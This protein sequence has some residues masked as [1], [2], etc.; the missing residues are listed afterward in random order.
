MA[1]FRC[2]VC[3]HGFESFCLAAT[4]LRVFT[5]E[6]GPGVPASSSPCH[7]AFPSALGR[8]RGLLFQFALGS[9]VSQGYLD[10]YSK[11]CSKEQPEIRRQRLVQPGAEPLGRLPDVQTA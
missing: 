1:R 8:L 2:H 7:T 4:A 11:D 9:D 3:V 5:A 10:Q 6:K